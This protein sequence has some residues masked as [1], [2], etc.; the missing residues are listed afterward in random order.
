MGLEGTTTEMT[1]R[2]AAVHHAILA[3]GLVILLLATP[4]SAWKRKQDLEPSSSGE[5]TEELPEETRE[6]EVFQVP[7]TNGEI[8]VDGQLDAGEWDS[9]LEL[10]LDYETRPGENIDPPVETS[11]YVTHNDSYLYAACRA[12]DPE[13]E[14]I[15][16]RLS[17][18]DRAFSDDFV[19]IVVDPFNDER[20]AFEFF[21]NPLGVQMDLFNDDVGGRESESWDAIWD[22]AGRITEEGYEV[23][24]AIPFH[25][26]RFPKTNGKQVWGFD[27][28]R[29]YPRNQ[30]HR[31]ALQPMDRDVN[32]YL[33]QISKLEG[34]EG[35]SPGR[36]L[37]IVPTLTAGRTETREDLP[38]GDF[39]D[40]GVDSDPGVT[41]RW[42]VTPNLT[43]GATV[44]PDFSQV[45]ADVAQLDVNTTFTL[46]FPERRPFFLEGADFFST[47]FN[48]V[49]TRNVSDPDW[50]TKL[51]G[52]MGKNAIGL[53]VAQ[54]KVTTLLF[55]G[56]QGSDLDIFDF[57]T[58]DAV[59]RYRRD[60]GNNSA[61]GVLA[62]GR[63]GDDY[64]NGVAGVDGLYRMGD[65]DSIRFQFLSS[66]TEYP[67]TIATDFDQPMGSFSDQ[68]YTVRYRHS[69]RNWNWNVMRQ[70]VGEDFRADLGFMPRVGT[71]FT[72]GG[73][74]RNFWGEEDDWY[75]RITMGS[76]W[77]LTEDS[78]GQVLEREFE[79]RGSVG[80]PKQSYL[81]LNVGDRERY[82]DGVTFDE[83][84]ANTWFEISPTGKS[85]FGLFAWVGD[86][87]DFANTQAGDSVVV[88]PSIRYDIGLHLR[89]RLD[90]TYSKLNVAGG[91][92]FEA[93]LSQLRLVYQ[94]NVRMFAR[95]IFQ[96]RDV[97]R[98]PTLYEDEV[99][100][101]SQSLLTQ[102]LFSYKLNPQTVLFVGYSDNRVA[103]ES[104]G[105]TASDRAL[106][107][108]LGYAW[109]L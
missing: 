91:E 51:T 88:E 87:I 28:V 1:V 49:F 14:T 61:I 106:F 68:A 26:L 73:F 5:I 64:S 27:A 99:D 100:P 53:F 103:E 93:N 63:R 84:F 8:T 82:F 107:F 35:I 94:F 18:R 17:D 85:W 59:V 78:T 108:K 44:N 72:L 65:S 86:S 76:D 77:D 16:A 30:R 109:V 54:D 21:V 25:Q 69:E 75:T 42:G 22:S 12:H 92:L 96:Y 66:S 48:A 55:P 36:N 71:T 56:P 70:D 40:G 6:A 52:K 4:A 47:P 10:S 31:I 20:R 32:C 11:C 38:D 102:L 29:F 79:I 81:W 98:D 45:E 60:F 89:A 7:A 97:V 39:T 90:H 34:F 3:L 2:R 41:V 50:G 95:A 9:A 24:M 101:E 57:E 104:F 80:G 33:C 15:R 37:E 58:T 19:G 46:F 13:P 43:V 62:T 105:L 23:E 74:N 83:R 67:G